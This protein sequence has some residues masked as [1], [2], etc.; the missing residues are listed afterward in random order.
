MKPLL[1]GF[2]LGV[3][4]TLWVASFWGVST[5]VSLSF[6]S[7]IAFTCAVMVVSGL[8]VW[9]IGRQFGWVQVAEHSQPLTP[10]R[11]TRTVDL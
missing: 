11:E 4:S 8:V 9:W 5:C 3:T 2:G 6:V 10:P 7:G 1:A